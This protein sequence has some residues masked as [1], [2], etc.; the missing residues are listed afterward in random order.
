MIKL[1]CDICGT[2][3]EN[4][5]EKEEVYQF[6]IVSNRN[7]FQNEKGVFNALNYVF[8]ETCI[9]KH[10]EDIKNIVVRTNDFKLTYFNG[11]KLT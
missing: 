3:I 7:I 8:C 11:V 5:S 6:Q 1:Y 9:N 2:E 4:T 10:A